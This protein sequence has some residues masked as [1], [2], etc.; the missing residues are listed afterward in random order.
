MAYSGKIEVEGIPEIFSTIIRF[1]CDDPNTPGRDWQII[2]TELDNSSNNFQWIRKTGTLTIPSANTW[3]YL[4]SGFVTEYSFT[5]N[6]QTLQ[7]GVDYQLN[8]ILGKI[9]IINSSFNFPLNINYDYK[10]KR[11]RIIIKNNGLWGEDD[12]F[13]GFLLLSQGYDRANVYTTCYK[14]LNTQFEGFFTGNSYIRS[15]SNWNF[16]FHKDLVN[17]WIFSNKRRIII[18]I[19]SNTYYSYCYVGSFLPFCMPHEYPYPLV[20]KTDLWGNPDLSSIIWYDSTNNN[21]HFLAFGSYEGV[22]FSN[23]WGRD[24]TILPTSSTSNWLTITYMD[25]YNKVLWPLY[26][27]KNF[28][29]GELDG[30]YYIPD[31]SNIAETLI[32]I[33][34][35][36]YLIVPNCWRI[37]W[38]NWIAIK[39]I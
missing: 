12:I 2:F 28:P 33:D 21:R 3:V 7:E 9:K 19:R 10:F 23:Y 20:I 1:L 27:Y 13:V 15:Q 6:S 30:V 24:I 5:Y 22:D 32:T 35:I 39:C 11:Y 25:D 4:P 16:G 26:L 36:N 37:D 8:W 18:V 14:I 38:T 31:S 17:L 29:L 34:E